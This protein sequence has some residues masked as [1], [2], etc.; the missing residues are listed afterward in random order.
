MFLDRDIPRTV[1]LTTA[2]DA[3]KLV[4]WKRKRKEKGFRLTEKETYSNLKK[5]KGKNVKN[6]CN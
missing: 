4:K 6:A 3:H 1:M 5:P 2:T